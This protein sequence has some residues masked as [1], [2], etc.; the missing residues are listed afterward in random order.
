MKCFHCT[1]IART[2]ARNSRP[3][4]PLE[5]GTVDHLPT[6]K[7]ITSA[8]IAAACLQTGREHGASNDEV[9]GNQHFEG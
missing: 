7:T 8:E 2:E 9:K 6:S 3:N 1:R 4:F 5:P